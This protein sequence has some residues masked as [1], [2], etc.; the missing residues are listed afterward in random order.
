MSVL[1]T[2][3]GRARWQAG[4]VRV[5]AL[6][7]LLAAAVL[8]GADT[9]YDQFGPSLSSGVFDEL[10]HVATG[11]L[12]LNLLPR[13]WRNP[14]LAP[15]LLA[16]V[17]IDLDHVPQYVFHVYWFTQGTPRPYTH[18]LLSVVVCLVLALAW[19]RRRVMWV[20]VAVGLALHFVRDLGEGGGAGVALLWPV[21]DHAFAYSHRLYLS[22]M[23]AA[24]GLNLLLLLR[25]RLAHTPALTWRAPA[26]SGTG[27]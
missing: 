15:A 14:I 5:S 25:E 26:G 20:G 17:L 13:R 7:V 11:L 19:R 16:S 9:L 6:Q 8:L 12:C 10:A 22:L 18:S 1:T 21:S 4:I 24:V 27:R 2:S 23:A 3:R